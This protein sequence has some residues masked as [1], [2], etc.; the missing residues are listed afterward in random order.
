MVCAIALTA[1][2]NKLVFY[3]LKSSL[4][5]KEKNLQKKIDFFQKNYVFFIFTLQIFYNIFCNFQKFTPKEIFA[6]KNFFLQK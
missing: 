2:R 3:L 5:M 1:N 4:K 6:L